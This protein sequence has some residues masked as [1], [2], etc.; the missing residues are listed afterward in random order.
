MRDGS[1][2]DVVGAYVARIVDEYEGCLPGDHEAAVYFSLL[3]HAAIGLEQAHQRFSPDTNYRAQIRAVL[4]A[5]HNA[6]P[7]KADNDPEELLPP[8]ADL[9]ELLAVPEE[10]AGQARPEPVAQE[11]REGSV[12]YWS[13]DSWKKDFHTSFSRWFWD[14]KGY[15][16][17][18]GRRKADFLWDVAEVWVATAASALVYYAKDDRVRWFETA[19]MLRHY[20]DLTEADGLRSLPWGRWGRHAKENHRPKGPRP[21]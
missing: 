13:G 6:I 11:V 3:K 21:A 18:A 2:D 4:A 19:Q 15:A 8:E 7:A 5:M 10:Q 12:S 16:L 17:P 20:A 14:M 9:S 1:L